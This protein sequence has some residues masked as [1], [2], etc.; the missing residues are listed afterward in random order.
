MV[1]KVVPLETL[2]PGQDAR[3]ARIVGRGDDVH[4]LEEFGLRGGTRLRM[5]RCGNPCIVRV[6]GGKVCLRPQ[7]RLRILVEPMERS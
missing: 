3:V 2:L 1:D 7:D 5:F 6:A 4:R